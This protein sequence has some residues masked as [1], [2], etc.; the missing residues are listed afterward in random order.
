[1]LANGRVLIVGGGPSGGSVAV[2]ELYDPT[3]QTFSAIAGGS[4]PMRQDH[5]ATLLPGGR[6]LTAGGNNIGTGRTNAELYDPLAAKWTPTG[7]LS[8]TRY[9]HTLTLLPNGHVLVAGGDD[10]D[11]ERGSAELYDPAAKTWSETGSMAQARGYHSA[12]LLPNGKVLVA[13]G[14][15]EGTGWSKGAELYDPATGAWTATGSLNV[16]R[17]DHSATLLADGRVLVAGGE[18]TGDYL[19]SAE[20]YD[21]ETG[22]WTV[23]GQMTN[24]RGFHGATLLT[25]AKVLV[26]GGFNDAYLAGVELYDPATGLWSNAKDLNAARS[27]HSATL[28]PSGQVQVAG[29]GNGGGYPASGEVY[30]PTIDDWSD[31]SPLTTPRRNHSATLLDSGQVLVVGGEVASGYLADAELFDPASKSWLSAGSMNTARDLH[32]ATLLLDGQVLVAGGQG[33]GGSGVGNADLYDLGLGFQPAWRPLLGSATTPLST[34]DTLMAVGAGWRGFGNTEAAGGGPNSSATNFPLVQLYRLEGGQTLWLPTATFSETELSTHA[35]PDFPQGHARVAIF[36]NGIPS[37]ARVILITKNY[38]ISPTA[39]PNGTISPGTAQQVNAGEDIT[40]TI[41]AATGYQIN[42][43]RVDGVSQGAVSS[44]TF[45]DVNADHAIDATFAINRYALDVKKSGDGTGSVSSAPEGIN[46]GN[47]CTEEYD[48]GTAV[49]LNAQAD[50]GSAFSGWSGACDTDGKVVMN[51]DKSCTATFTV[52]SYVLEIKKAGDGSGSVSSTPSGISCGSTCSKEYDHGAVVRLTARTD[53]GSAFSGWSG[54]CDADGKV[55]MNG[56]KSC[57]ATFTAKRYTLAPTAGSNGSISPGTDQ[58]VEYGESQTFTITPDSGF[59]IEDV[60]VDGVSQGAQG[61]F[62]F[63]NVDA[64]HTIE[65]FFV[66][67]ST[68]TEIQIYL[69][70]INR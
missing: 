45:T 64:D 23:T 7:S 9:G 42:D 66:A 2:G 67:K 17:S 34:G 69:P 33:T 55:V 63:S 52:N 32:R 56:D 13:G 20:I 30:D 48:H 27:S 57:T 41:A 1:M 60:R 12:T 70:L 62:V 31:T 68:E 39:G 50:A 5:T 8:T 29:G 10:S 19:D 43:V 58:I 3:S 46:Y 49:T 65:A 24:R 54:A 53:A 47:D 16:A 14:F 11:G 18:G 38:T 21:P 44:Y 26:S 25:N 28:L 36:V 51:G 40:F 37:Q 59:R 35:L 6:V 15:K 61:E 4:I 22:K